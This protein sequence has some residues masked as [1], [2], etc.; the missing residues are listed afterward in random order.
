MAQLCSFFV[1]GACTRGA[2][3]PYRHEM[4]STGEL[5][6]Q[7]IKDRYYGTNDPVAKKMLN[8]LENMPKLEPPEDKTITTLFIGGVT[9]EIS[10]E[11]LR[12][13]FY[14]FGEL[15]SVKKVRCGQWLPRPPDACGWLC[16]RAISGP[17]LVHVLVV[18]VVCAYG[19]AYVRVWVFIQHAC[20]A[21]VCNREMCV[22]VALHLH[23]CP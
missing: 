4:P 7:N 19:S 10:E 16:A 21:G 8:R 17:V 9:D 23:A 1:R 14:A 15:A 11:D 13:K 3:C 12:D 2:E 20:G 6:E 5:A 18:V 22:S